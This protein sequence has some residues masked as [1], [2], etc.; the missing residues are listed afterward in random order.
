M[1]YAK[2]LGATSRQD[3]YL[4]GNG[5]LVSWCV[6]HLVELAPPN[7]YDAKYV[8][9]SIADLPILPQ[10]WQ[11]LVST[12]TKKQF[13]ILKD[14]MNRSDVDIIVNACEAHLHIPMADFVVYVVVAAPVKPDLIGQPVFHFL[15][16]VA[17]FQTL[18]ALFLQA[19]AVPQVVQKFLNYI[20]RPFL[21]HG[22]HPL[23]NS[24]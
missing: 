6:G 19:Q 20:C 12:S 5:Y 23:T 4:E 15:F 9:W 17:L 10:K 1:S 11:Y 21:F 18:P 22:L 13:G 3:G 16:E 7:V 8:K 14:L 24:L 2:V